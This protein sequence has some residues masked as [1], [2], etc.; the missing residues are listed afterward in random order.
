MEMLAQELACF[1]LAELSS[2]VELM[3][4]EYLGWWAAHVHLHLVPV[5]HH[6]VLATLGS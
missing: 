2:G 5:P 3:L 6:T 4:Q 1:I